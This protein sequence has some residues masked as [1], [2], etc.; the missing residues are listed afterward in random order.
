MNKNFSFLFYYIG[1][2]LKKST[3]HCE[4]KRKKKQNIRAGPLSNRIL[5]YFFKY[6]FEKIV[7]ATE[8]TTTTTHTHK[9]RRSRCRRRLESILNTGV[10]FKKID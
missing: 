7:L 5:I 3:A 8:K 6:Y 1:L 9:R 10:I 4:L 2:L